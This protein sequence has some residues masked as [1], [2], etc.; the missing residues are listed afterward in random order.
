MAERKKRYNF[1]GERWD[2]YSTRYQTRRKQEK[3]EKEA[4]QAKKLEEYQAILNNP[5]NYDDEVIR[6]TR[7]RYKTLLKNQKIQKKDVPSDLLIPV[8]LDERT[9]YFIREKNIF[10]NRW[11]KLF[12]K[13]HL[14][15][16][17][18]NYKKLLHLKPVSEFYWNPF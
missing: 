14:Q 8:R 12:G 6:V 9:V 3:E 15:N 17:L 18:D 13:E 16:L 2:K 1:D 11:I 10:N 4:A 7:L 5:D